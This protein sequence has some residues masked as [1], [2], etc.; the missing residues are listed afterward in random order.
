VYKAY[1]WNVRSNW[2]RTDPTSLSFTLRHSKTIATKKQKSVHISIEAQSNLPQVCPVL[3]MNH[4]LKICR[5]TQGPL[6]Q[7]RYNASKAKRKIA[8]NIIQ[9]KILDCWF[10]T[11]H[12]ILQN[13]HSNWKACVAGSRQ[14]ITTFD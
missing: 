14:I 2:W 5:P 11:L 9:I 6:F 13:I 12:N 4:Y 3:A 8:R 1:C 10:Y 7:F